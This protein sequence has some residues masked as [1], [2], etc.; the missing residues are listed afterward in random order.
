[1]FMFL[2]FLIIGLAFWKGGDPFRIAGDV[3]G[4]AGKTITRF[5]DF[6]DDIKRGGKKVEQTYN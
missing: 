2:L 1:M 5:G 3:I 6:V 4:D